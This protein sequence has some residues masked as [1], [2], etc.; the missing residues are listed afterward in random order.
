MN[1]VI[2]DVR[3]PAEYATGHS[4]G[5]L[6]IPTATIQAG[7]AELDALPKDTDIIVYCQSG[8][9]SN[10][11]M[12]ALQQLGFTHVVNGINQQQ[13]QEKYGF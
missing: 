5:A 4:E 8:G 7:A 12:S 13:V 10:M 9:R 1:H 3:E 2:I 6:N 11:A